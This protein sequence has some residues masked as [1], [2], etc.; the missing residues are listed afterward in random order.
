MELVVCNSKSARTRG[1][2]SGFPN[3]VI[4]EI[5]SRLDAQSVMRC[6]CVCKSWLS[7]ITHPSFKHRH[8]KNQ[9]PGALLRADDLDCAFSFHVNDNGNHRLWS[10][11]CPNDYMDCPIVDEKQNLRMIVFACENGVICLSYRNVVYLWNPAIRKMKKLPSLPSPCP[12]R[13]LY[14]LGYH[15]LTDDFKV[16]GIPPM[17]TGGVGFDYDNNFKRGNLVGVYSLRGPSSWKTLEMPDLFFS[18]PN[19]ANHQSIF[20]SFVL[21]GSIHWLVYYGREI[22]ETVLESLG[23]VAFDMSTEVFKLINSPP[24]LGGLEAYT[25]KRMFDLSGCL[26]LLTFK[27]PGL[28]DM[29]VMKE[30]GVSDSWTKHFSFNLSKSSVPSPTDDDFML[31]PLGLGR[32]SNGDLLLYGGDVFYLYNSKCNRVEYL[33]PEFSMFQFTTYV[34][35]IFLS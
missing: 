10:H 11:P 2:A 34:E 14:G 3:D 15:T 8:L 19:C 6:K 17:K 25:A 21:N 16:V 26:S 32:Y 28:I 13:H 23:I 18:D 9:V 5:L 22:E 31:Y 24:S 27:R 35:S 12:M 7:L 33:R 20:C 29:W 4:E 1:A 30:Y